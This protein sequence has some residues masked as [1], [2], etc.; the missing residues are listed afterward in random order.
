[1]EKRINY[2]FRKYLSNSCTEEELGEFLELIRISDQDNS[3]REML[4]ETYESILVASDTYV[5]D[6]GRLVIPGNPAPVPEKKKRV[7][8][9]PLSVAAAVLVL[10]TLTAGVYWTLRPHTAAPQLNAGLKKSSTEKAE[11]KYLLLPDSTQVWLNVGSTLEYPGQFDGATREVSLSGEAYFDVKHA[12]E[13]PF[14]IH[15]GQI[16]TT[17]LGTAFNINAYVDHPDVRVSVSRGKVK[18]S[19]GVQTIA[20][21]VKGQEVKVSQQ[22]NT[23][24]EKVISNAPVAAWQQGILYYDDE[25][26]EAVISDL[27][28][29]YNVNI[30][31]SQNKTKNLRLSTSFR[32]EIGI[33]QAL[34]IL[35]NLSDTQL[36]EKNGIYLI[37]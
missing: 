11:Y 1:M 33:S 3:L 17:V 27:Q 10:A 30:K 5:N 28:R 2:L 7:F 32:R 24:L 23:P 22:D 31:I 36:Y 19:R 16:T 34:E 25:T 21:L 20:L 13:H 4:R 35:C 8:L 12:A 6:S 37:Q 9:R 18:V 29:V 26:M 15:T 14:I